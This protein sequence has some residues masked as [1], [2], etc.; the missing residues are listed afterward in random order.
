MKPLIVAVEAI[1]AALLSI[2]EW[3]K[4]KD[5]EPVPAPAPTP[6][7]PAPKLFFAYALPDNLIG[8]LWT[9]GVRVVNKA[10]PALCQQVAAFGGAIIGSQGNYERY[11]DAEGNYSPTLMDA[12]IDSHAPYAEAL[13]ARHDEGSLP[14]IQAADDWAGEKNWPTPDDPAPGLSVDELE[15]I[16]AKWAA[17]VPG[18]PLALRARPRQFPTRAPQGYRVF[19]CQYRLWDMDGETPEE[20]MEREEMRAA[21]LGVQL[22]WSI[23]LEHGGTNVQG[24]KGPMTPEQAEHALSV[25]A[26]ASNSVGIG[27]WKWSPLVE[28]PAYHAV[29]TRVKALLS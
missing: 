2:V 15:R 13:K 9:A 23:N 1:I 6:P 22:A 20:F 5:A 17:V 27:L 8:E 11:R 25:F 3:L 10:L 26:T 24:V 4:L 7:P 12:I 28:E 29:W 21:E 16:A 14:F 19:I 18:V